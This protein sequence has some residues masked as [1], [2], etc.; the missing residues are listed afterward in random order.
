[1]KLVQR[2]TVCHAMHITKSVSDQGVKLVPFAIKLTR[3][4]TNFGAKINRTAFMLRGETA[5][6]GRTS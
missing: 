1:M 2:F 4:F 3:D 5:M 6:A